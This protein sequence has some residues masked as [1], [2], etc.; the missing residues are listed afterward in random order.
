M[1]VIGILIT[2]SVY[3]L[4]FKI[5]P[6]FFNFIP[7]T[8]HDDPSQIKWIRR[9]ED[10]LFAALRLHNQNKNPTE[11]HHSSRNRIS[12]FSSP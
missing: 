12:K 4:C 8:F 6:M 7:S 1:T 2:D 11:E 5:E 9:F 10:A 3:S